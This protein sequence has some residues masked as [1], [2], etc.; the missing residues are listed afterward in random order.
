MIGVTNQ[1]PQ[2]PIRDTV[3][4]TANKEEM[5]QPH[6]IQTFTNDELES[7]TQLRVRAIRR[8]R[9]RAIIIQK[10]QRILDHNI[11]MG[12]VNQFCFSPSYLDWIQECLEYQWSLLLD[13]I[14]TLQSEEEADQEMLAL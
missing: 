6:R 9:M 5:D 7:L 8:A 1:R 2:C 4:S 3:S 12:T 10:A 13:V 11:F 14:S